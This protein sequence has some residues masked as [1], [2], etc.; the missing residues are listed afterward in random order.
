MVTNTSK[1]RNK[2]NDMLKESENEALESY[3]EQLKV[4]NMIKI[5]EELVDI[6]KSVHEI[7]MF[8]SDK[9]KN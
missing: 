1:W 8:L 9:I 5:K 2:M 7:E 3:K 4:Y 6:K